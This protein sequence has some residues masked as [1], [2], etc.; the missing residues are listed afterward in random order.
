MQLHI[1]GPLLDQIITNALPVPWLG[2]QNKNLQ[3]IPKK[4]ET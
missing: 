3:G 2:V 4:H 1:R